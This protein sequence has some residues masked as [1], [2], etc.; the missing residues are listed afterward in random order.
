M[1]RTADTLSAKY[2]DIVSEFTKIYQ[3]T[4][5]EKSFENLIDIDEDGFHEVLKILSKNIIF[6]IRGKRMINKNHEDYLKYKEAFDNLVA[7]EKNEIQNV[8][9]P[10]A[11]RF[12]GEYSKIHKKYALKIKALQEK[13]NY[14]FD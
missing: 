10:N 3:S 2:S 4:I 7:E 14:L 13:Y 6:N 1:K 8:K 11:K 9:S 12:D 5:Y